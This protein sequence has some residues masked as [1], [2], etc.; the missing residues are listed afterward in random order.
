M[1][2][3]PKA[4]AHLVLHSADLWSAA[5]EVEQ[6]LVTALH[7]FEQLGDLSGQAHALNNL[8]TRRAY[9]GQLARR[10]ANVRPAADRFRRVGDAS[11]AANAD[12]N[13]G[14]VL[15]RQGA[16]EEAWPLLR[17]L[18]ESPAQSATRNSWPSCR[19]SRAGPKAA[20]VTWRQ[21]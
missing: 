18:C 7:L 21:D 20:P 11:N 1:S 15:V 6:H 13:R 12:Y 8:A 9:A 2:F 16:V 3:T 19:E 4:E 10:L 5:P 14:D 17:K